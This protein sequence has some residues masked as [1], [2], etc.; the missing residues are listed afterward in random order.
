MSNKITNSGCTGKSGDNGNRMGIHGLR[1]AK[2]RKRYAFAVHGELDILCRSDPHWAATSEDLGSRTFGESKRPDDSKTGHG[3][4]ARG[5]CS[6]AWLQLNIGRS[7]RSM[8]NSTGIQ[9]EPWTPSTGTCFRYDLAATQLRGK[10]VAFPASA[11]STA[12]PSPALDHG[13][14]KPHATAS[15]CGF[16]SL[17]PTHYTDSSARASFLLFTQGQPNFIL[18]DRRAPTRF[19]RDVWLE[20]ESS[21]GTH[22]K[23]SQPETWP[24]RSRAQPSFYTKQQQSPGT[25][26]LPELPTKFTRVTPQNLIHIEAPPVNSLRMGPRSRFMLAVLSGGDSSS[27]NAERGLVD[28]R[29]R[30]WPGQ[31][32]PYDHAK[33]YKPKKS[34]GLSISRKGGTCS[35]MPRVIPSKPYFSTPTTRKVHS[36]PLLEF[37]PGTA[38]FEASSDSVANFGMSEMMSTDAGGAG[39]AIPLVSMGIGGT[40]GV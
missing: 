4:F 16:S 6:L 37:S 29:V 30:R 35:S 23:C 1:R 39:K 14:P 19:G 22:G 36:D 25:W 38:F 2:Q 12:S 24:T 17:P 31:A 20:P 9:V 40:F 8:T 10:F 15:S 28:N 34:T 13:K 5:I 26:R 27:A 7:P 3:Y 11:G 18:H 21:R 32:V 33:G